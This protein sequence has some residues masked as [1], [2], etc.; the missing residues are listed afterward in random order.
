LGRKIS[1]LYFNFGEEDFR[2]L[3]EY[4]RP[5]RMQQT[6]ANSHVSNRGYT[7]SV[8]FNLCP[9][10]ANSSAWFYVY[11]LVEKETIWLADEEIHMCLEPII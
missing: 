11:V 10:F 8:N 3:K 1:E 5:C 6:V 7:V 9:V 4:L 2:F